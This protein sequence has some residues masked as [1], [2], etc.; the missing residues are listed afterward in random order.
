MEYYR[1][2]TGQIY[3][4]IAYRLGRIVTQYE[5]F[6]INEEK[7]ESTLYVTV[8]QNLLTNCSDYVR[9]MTKGD[10]H[11]SIFNGDIESSGWGL[12]NS[13]W[14]KN[15]LMKHSNLG[16][17]ILTIRNSVSHPCETRIESDYPSTGYTTIED[18]SGIIKKFIFINSPD[19]RKNRPKEYNS[20][21]D[22]ERHINLETREGRMP[23]GISYIKCDNRYVLA[24]NSEYFIRISIIELT[25]E[26]LSSFVK[27][28]SNYLAQ[29]ILE[30][31]DGKTI[32]W[33]L[34][35]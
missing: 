8:L 34:A 9:S 28:L 30:N 23:E 14:I 25:I 3:A 19:V 26:E 12:K 29:P 18:D 6:S 20:E 17:F 27:N 16:D 4:D 7:F 35:A 21:Q 22:V 31:W 11:G 1:T 10:R 5:E 15:N 33:L 13:C 2:E 32:N 24:L